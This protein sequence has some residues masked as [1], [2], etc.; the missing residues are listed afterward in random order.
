MGA[1]SFRDLHVWQKAFELVLAIYRL[2]EPFPR[3]EIYGLTQQM[4]RAAISIPSNIAEGFK[5]YHSKE[6][7]Q[8]LHIA[9]GSCAELET[10]LNISKELGYAPEGDYANIADIINHISKMLT[11][12][13]KRL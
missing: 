12:L 2:T 1:K 8:F 10:Q 5:R 11:N 9:L 7:R 13:I 3:T 4:R 6:Y